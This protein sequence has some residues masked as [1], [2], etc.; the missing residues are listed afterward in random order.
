M[1]ATS[2]GFNTGQPNFFFNSIPIRYAK[3]LTNTPNITA[4]LFLPFLLSLD[5]PL[6]RHSGD[7][8]DDEC[9]H[10]GNDEHRDH[11]S[12]QLFDLINNSHSRRINITGIRSRSRFPVTSTSE[13]LMI[14][15]HRPP[16]RMN[17]PYT[18]AGT[19]SGMNLFKSSPTI[20][21]R[22]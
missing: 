18:P 22:R 21:I 2:S 12:L 3:R 11:D 20:V 5:D 15:L 10:E 19:G 1:I 4:S 14:P 16:R 8:H 7:G 6:C 13:S 17:R 9:G